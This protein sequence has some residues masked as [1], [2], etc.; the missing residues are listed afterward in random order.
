MKADLMMMGLLLLSGAFSGLLFDFYRMMRR[1]SRWRRTATFIGDVLF[2][3]V[4]LGILVFVFRKA[5]YLELRFYLFLASLTG[6]AL[7]LAMLSR[8]AKRFFAGF[9]GLSQQVGGTLSYQVRGWF[10]VVNR[11]CR[12]LLA[13]PYG[14]LRWMGLLIYRILEAIALSARRSVDTLKTERSRRKRKQE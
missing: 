8:S 5:N 7:Y 4:V 10:G 9:F 6:L 3:M 11:L 2:S 1:G 12:A 13:I 14:I